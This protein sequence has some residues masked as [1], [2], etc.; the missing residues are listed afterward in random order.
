MN[1]TFYTGLV[2]NILRKDIYPISYKCLRY[3]KEKCNSV[4]ILECEYDRGTCK[5][6]IPKNTK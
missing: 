1:I 4:I 6:Y 5:N 3:M 2:P